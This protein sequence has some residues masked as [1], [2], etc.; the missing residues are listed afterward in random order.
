MGNGMIEQL[1][2]IR[3]DSYKS[4][5]EK[6]P[7]ILSLDKNVTL[8]IGRNNCGKS[9][10]LDVVETVFSAKKNKIPEGMNAISPSFRLDKDK[11]E[12]VF[13]KELN[14]LLSGYG[15]DRAYG[16]KFLNHQIT[17]DLIESGNEKKLLTSRHQIEIYEKGLE[18]PDPEIYAWNRTATMYSRDLSLCQLRRL[19]ADRDIVPEYES[20][21]E[22]VSTNGNGATNL[23]RR[24]INTATYDEGYVE[25]IILKELNTIMEPD[26]HFTA[27][28]VQQIGNKSADNKYKWEMFLEEDGHRYSLSRSGSGLK[29]IILILINLYLIPTTETNRL[30]NDYLFAF[31][32]IENN[33][34]PALQRRLFE[35]LYEYA[36]KYDKKIVIT[37]HSHIAINMLY[38]KEHAR[39][40]HV[41]KEKNIS[42]L[43]EITSGKDCGDILDEVLKATI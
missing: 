10:L 1:S 27:I 14:T 17:F 26:A 15:N 13:S 4:F 24:I 7:F 23:V 35:Y 42:E 5:S 38:G 25:K 21:H 29:T 18:E 41:I 30:Y 37:S 33:L 16:Y 19:N 32:E 28:R 9:S 12:T 11:I 39:L 31:E 43:V 2:S 20:D 3:F 36:I 22:E 34:H 40:Y 6:G 8:I